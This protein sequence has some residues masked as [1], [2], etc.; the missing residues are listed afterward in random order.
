MSDP[1]PLTDTEKTLQRVLTAYR[2]R[3]G[4]PSTMRPKNA[5]SLGYLFAAAHRGGSIYSPFG[6]F[7]ADEMVEWAVRVLGWLSEERVA[8]P[9]VRPSLKWEDGWGVAK[10][11][12]ERVFAEKFDAD[13]AEMQEEYDADPVAFPECN[14]SAVVVDGKVT[15]PWGYDYAASCRWFLDHMSAFT[16]FTVWQVANDAMER[17]AEDQLGLWADGGSY[18]DPRKVVHEAFD[19]LIRNLSDH[20]DAELKAALAA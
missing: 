1:T 3:A 16:V 5:T 14:S 18:G 13:R 8:M 15:D 10:P 6:G 19:N 12:I 17:A 9:R 11:L 4:R 7:K 2:D 20:I